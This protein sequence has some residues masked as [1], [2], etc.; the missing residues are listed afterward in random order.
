ME[1]TSSPI[2]EAHT[3]WTQPHSSLAPYSPASRVVF[4]LVGLGGGTGACLPGTLAFFLMGGT[5][6][7]LWLAPA[8]APFGGTGVFLGLGLGLGLGGAE[9]GRTGAAGVSE[10]FSEFSTNEKLNR[11]D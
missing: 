4:R 1:E 8:V 2:P 3:P 11:A 5:S 6:S 9:G 10:W 7:P